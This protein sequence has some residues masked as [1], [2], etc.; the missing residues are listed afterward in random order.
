MLHDAK[1]AIGL[2]IVMEQYAPASSEGARPS[3]HLNFKASWT[4]PRRRA[5]KAS[6]QAAHG[7]NN[8][9]GTAIIEE[10]GEWQ[11]LTLNSVDCQFIDL[12]KFAVTKSRAIFVSRRLS[13]SILVARH[14]R[15]A[16]RC[17][18]CS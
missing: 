18:A 10:D 8:S 13:F 7:G 5:M 9:G 6:W 2:A 1:N 16:N 4:R 12:R 17:R 15:T 14:G 3:G 11:P